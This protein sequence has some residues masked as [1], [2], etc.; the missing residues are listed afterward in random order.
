MKLPRWMHHLYANLFGYFW[1]PCPICHEYF[2]GHEVANIETISV[3]VGSRAYIVCPKEKCISEA[4]SMN[5]SAW[6]KAP[7]YKKHD[8]P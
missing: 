6:Y 4:I 2:G 7:Y 8:R 1:L 5:F 3:P